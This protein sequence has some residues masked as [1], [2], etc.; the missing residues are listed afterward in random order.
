MME[1]RDIFTIE[2]AQLPAPGQA[3]VSIWQ[4]PRWNVSTDTMLSPNQSS[5]TDWPQ[6]LPIAL[7]M[8]WQEKERDWLFC[9]LAMTVAFSLIAHFMMFIGKRISMDY[10]DKMNSDFLEKWFER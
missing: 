10:H 9:V 2:E 6:A 1:K 7:L 5:L 4:T 8:L 3:A